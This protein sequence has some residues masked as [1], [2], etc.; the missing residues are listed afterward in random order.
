MISVSSYLVQGFGDDKFFLHLLQ[1][2]FV[3]SYSITLTCSFI[4]AYEGGQLTYGQHCKENF[5][6]CCDMSKSRVPSN[7]SARILM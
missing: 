3:W 7:V 4:D 5:G 6:P 2:S 1:K